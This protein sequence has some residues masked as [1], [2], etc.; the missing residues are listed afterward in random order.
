MTTVSLRIATTAQTLF[1]ANCVMLLTLYA[2]TF[3]ARTTRTSRRITAATNLPSYKNMCK[4]IEANRP[5]VMKR[6]AKS[7]QLDYIVQLFGDNE[8]DLDMNWVSQLEVNSKT[9]NAATT[10][11]NIRI[12]VRNDPRFKGTFYFDEFMERPM[13]CGDLP[14]RK[15]EG[16][17]RSWDDTDDAGVHNIFRKGL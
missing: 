6:T 17:P 2:Y 7:K 5:E 8:E 15:L 4:W 1:A 9:G 14:W 16:K 13:V 11:E 10:V 3:L 12:I